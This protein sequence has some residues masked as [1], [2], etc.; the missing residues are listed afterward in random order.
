M[1]KVIALLVAAVAAEKDG[2]CGGEKGACDDAKHCCAN[3][4]KVD[5]SS[6]IG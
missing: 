2:E 3:I 1:N 6:F 4:T 5:M